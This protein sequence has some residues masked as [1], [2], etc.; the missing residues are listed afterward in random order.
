MSQTECGPGFDADG[1]SVVAHHDWDGREA[2]ETTLRGVV[3][4]LEID[5]DATRL[6]QHVDVEALR[7]VI[8]P[9]ADRGASQ[10]SFEYRQ[11]EIRVSDDGTVAVR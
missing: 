3:V 8:A 10:V 5:D 4:G 2:L 6:Y 1:W 9:D 7:D 11:Q